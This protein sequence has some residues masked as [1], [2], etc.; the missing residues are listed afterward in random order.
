MGYH[1]RFVHDRW[2]HHLW[3]PCSEL[4]NI[5]MYLLDA[6]LPSLEKHQWEGNVWFG[7]AL[8]QCS[9]Y[10]PVFSWNSLYKPG[11]PQTLRDLPASASQGLCWDFR[12]VLPHPMSTLFFKTVFS[13]NL[14]LTGLTRPIDQWAPRIHQS[15]PSQH[16]GFRHIWPY[17]SFY[18]DTGD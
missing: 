18:K 4:Q 6:H 9:I 12:H 13:L 1:A 10:G 3:T 15:L 14:K 2:A 16:H 8:R 11:W 5:Y 17:P 7:L